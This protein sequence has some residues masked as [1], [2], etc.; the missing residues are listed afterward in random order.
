MK[1]KSIIKVK[2]YIRRKS[3]S[4]PR[5]KTKVKSY[6]RRFKASTNDKKE[7]YHK[8]SIDLRFENEDEIFTKRVSPSI[9]REAYLILKNKIDSV[10]KKRN[11]TYSVKIQN[12]KLIINITSPCA[13]HKS[14]VGIINDLINY[15][16]SETILINNK[17]HDVYISKME[18]LSEIDNESLI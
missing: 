17:E 7:I 12:N 11:L 13:N 1:K 5:S 6:F 8:I 16:T 9:M 15:T 3:R 4:K 2:S 14:L 18:I 10:L